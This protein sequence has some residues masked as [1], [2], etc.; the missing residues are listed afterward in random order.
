MVP[1]EVFDGFFSLWPMM[2]SLKGAVDN[3][4]KD[5]TNFSV[6]Q[7]PPALLSPLPIKPNLEDL[8][9]KSD[10]NISWQHMECE[11]FGSLFEE[12]PHKLPEVSLFEG[13]QPRFDVQNDCDD[14]NCQGQD[15]IS[16]YLRCYEKY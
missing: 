11:P 6:P 12:E 5:T 4:A 2:Q 7:I 16:A 9:I 14:E 3:L 15:S 10:N 8:C 1:Q 13:T